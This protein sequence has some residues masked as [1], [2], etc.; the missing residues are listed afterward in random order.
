MLGNPFSPFTFYL[1]QPLSWYF[2][3]HAACVLQHIRP[4]V[5]RTSVFLFQ[6]GDAGITDAFCFLILIFYICSEVLGIE[7]SHE[8]FVARI[9]TT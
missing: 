6:C 5:V 9:F 3:C 1:R 7:F 4:L 8:D 2:S